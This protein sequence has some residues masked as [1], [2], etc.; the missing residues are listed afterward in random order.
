MQPQTPSNNRYILLDRTNTMLGQ[1]RLESPPT[2]ERLYVRV[3]S[4]EEAEEL[5]THEIV[6]FVGINDTLPS[7]LGHIVGHRNDVLIIEKSES[8]SDNVRQNFRMP[9]RF[10]SFIYPLT[11]SW[12]GRR[13]IVSEDL[14]CGGIAFYCKEPLEVGERMEIVIPITAQPLVL[15]CQ[16]LRILRPGDEQTS[17]LY[18]AKFVDM[19]NDE[20]VLTRE[21][22]FSVQLINRSRK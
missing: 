6:Q 3:G 20:E 15:R 5:S 17:T 21:A 7:L 4:E 1:G 16:I 14:S 2:A 18:A 12:T 22:V 19:C 11:G 9:V 10:D 13:Y 8:L